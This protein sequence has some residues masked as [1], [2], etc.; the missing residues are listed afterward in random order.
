[1]IESLQHRFVTGSSGQPIAIVENFPGTGAELNSKQLSRMLNELTDIQN[2][3][4][5]R[6]SE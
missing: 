5:R 4:R 2:E 6:E 1:M 3:M